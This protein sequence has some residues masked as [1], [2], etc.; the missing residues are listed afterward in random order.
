MKKKKNVLRCLG[1]SIALTATVGLSTLS[2]QQAEAATSSGMLS[3]VTPKDVV[4]QIITDRFVDGDTSNN[5]PTGS[6]ASLFDD[7]DQDG[8]G[9]GDDLKLYQGGD[10]Q[11]IIDKISYLKNMGVTAVWISAPYENRDTPIYDYQQSG[12][13]DL[14]TSFHGYHVRNYFATNKH[15]GLMQDFEALRDALHANGIKLI[16]DFVSNHTS[17]G[18]NPT[19]GNSPEDGKLYE[20]D[21]DSNG[22]YVFDSNGNPVDYNSDGNVENLLADPNYDINGWFHNLGDRGSDDTQFGY[23]FKD[24]GSLSDFSTENAAV[25]EHLEKAATFWKSKG[26][27]G[28]RH[29]ATLHMSPSFAKGFKDAIDSASGGPLTHF[30][31]FFIGRPDPKYDEYQSFPDRTGI[32]NLDFEYFRASTN[33]FGYFSETMSAFGQMLIATS[34]DYEYENQAVTFLDN[35]D[36]TRFRYIQPND[37]PYH[38]ALAT[39]LTAR[40]T[41]NIYYG[42]EQYLTSADSS[43]ISG[44]VFMERETSFDQTTT[45]YKIIQSLSALR[46]Q[47]E[48]VAYGETAI[49]Y[50]SDDVLV[51]KRQ[52]YDKQVIVA[53]NR[54]PDLSFTVPAINTTLPAG[55]YDDVLNGLLYGDS[56]TVNNGKIG[57]FTLAGGE[58]SVWSYNP[59]LGTAIPR[60][61]DVVST[62]G[63]AGNTVYI[64]GTGLGGTVT[65]KFDSTAAT[66]VS[67][68]D[69]MIEAIVPN[70]S[71]GARQITVTKGT[72]VSNQFRYEVLSDDQNQVIFKVNATTSWGVNI[73]IVGDIPE[74]GSWDTS[75][76]VGPFHTPNYPEWFLPVSVPKNTTIQ[77][78]FIKKDSSG[79]VTWEG[80][81]NRSIT[82]PSS[83]TG[84]LD[85]SV[86]T[87]Q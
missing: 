82:S 32:N 50:S 73:Y 7:P 81:N 47:N 72:N 21:K 41:P 24:L 22:D 34:A 14:W 12:G 48:A 49:L 20:P 23:R 40:G 19:S 33:A 58:V 16:I 74:L 4:Y 1:S 56:M 52:F 55:S 63:R 71:A 8:L 15:F 27:D 42:T 5:I 75:K 18:T 44:R 46:R 67:N 84:T 30:G 86:L 64:Y 53:V 43:D 66:V 61:G 3:P 57:S 37:K 28:F 6:S 85:T 79:N 76:A 26:V 77:Y 65:V 29:D 51:F 62:M 68:S 17:R 39:L 80:G 70:V 59:D 45:A 54:Q 11:G 31:E 35:H 36:V 9:N 38:A 87:W 25:V 60:I 10:W 2:A 69:T 13:Y 83:S 78:K